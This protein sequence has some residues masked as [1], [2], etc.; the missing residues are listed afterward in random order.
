MAIRSK[1]KSGRR[2]AGPWGKL[3]SVALLALN[4]AMIL[5]GIFYLL[6]RGCLLFRDIMGA[7][8]IMAWLGN[9]LLAYLNGRETALTGNF[10]GTRGKLS[11]AYLT[12]APLAMLSMLAGSLLLSASY[13]EAFDENII[14]YMM[15]YLGYFSL[16]LL[17]LVLS[18]LNLAARKGYPLF[19]G[20]PGRRSVFSTVVKALLALVLAFGLFMCLIM[21]A[22]FPIHEALELVASQ[23]ALFL[24]FVFLNISL[25]LQKLCR[26]DRQ[27][28]LSATAGIVGLIIFVIMLLPALSMPSA[29]SGAEKEFRAVYGHDWEERLDT[30]TTAHFMESRF[31]LPSYFLGTPSG[32]YRV[33]KDILYHEGN[34]DND[35]GIALYFD[36]YM[37]PEDSRELPGNNSVL[38]RIHGGGW[39]SGGKGM[40]NMMQMNKYFAA[41]G[42]VV[43]DVQYGLSYLQN[44]V[45]GIMRAP[46]HVLGPFTAD[47]M[48]RHLG[49]FTHYL[50]KHAADF[51]ANLDSVFISGGSAGGHLSTALALGSDSGNYPELFSPALTIKGFIPFYPG[52]D[53]D[54]LHEIGGSGEWMDV[55]TLVRADS[56]PCLIFQGSHDT[57]VPPEVSHSFQDRYEDAGAG[58]CAVLLMPLA[59]HAADLSFTGYY[60]STFL[61]YMERFMALY[62]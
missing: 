27:N 53:C 4:V 59:G 47:D 43:F 23:F 31:S 10:G 34:S 22:T 9:S 16:P 14:F 20:R 41:Q 42:Y 61:Y 60:N 62:R 55:K 3:G 57:L 33:E 6:E 36:A 45:E 7:V 32:N 37:P 56:P 28:G 18:C 26:D 46:D 58:K 19:R 12:A 29:I 44:T 54:L 35:E 52:N 1:L 13:S 48:V 5:M 49:I 51:G 40:R 38:I 2:P 24:A 15:V 50:E 8:M 21:L 17:G 30:D 39:Q 11:T 25:L